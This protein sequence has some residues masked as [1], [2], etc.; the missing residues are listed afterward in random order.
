MNRIPLL[1]ANFLAVQASIAGKAGEDYLQNQHPPATID[2]GAASIYA[3]VAILNRFLPPRV[4]VCILTPGY[5]SCWHR[6][7]LEAV[8]ELTQTDS[9]ADATEFQT[10]ALCVMLRQVLYLRDWCNPGVTAHDGC[11]SSTRRLVLG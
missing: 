9:I 2:A 6:K 5:I 1:S 10:T 4:Y 8:S 7:L 3:V 11:Y